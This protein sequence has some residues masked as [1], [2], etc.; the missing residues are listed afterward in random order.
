MAVRILEIEPEPERIAELLRPV[1]PRR[2]SGE[3]VVVEEGRGAADG[4][5][6]VVRQRL[7]QGGRGGGGG[8]REVR[9]EEAL[10]LPGGGGPDLLPG[11][12]R[13]QPRGGK[14]QRAAGP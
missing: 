14:T 8:R 1:E 5:E 13:A 7:Q 11:H 12:A 2:R 3:I 4:S 6:I 9:V 10:Q